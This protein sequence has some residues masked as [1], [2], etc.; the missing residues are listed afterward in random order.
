MIHD[1][2][3]DDF[4]VSLIRGTTQYFDKMY[5]RTVTPNNILIFV[6][7][8]STR[9]YINSKL[10]NRDL[11]EGQLLGFAYDFGITVA[12]L[13]HVPCQCAYERHSPPPPPPASKSALATWQVHFDNES[14]GNSQ[15]NP[16]SPK[17]E[18]S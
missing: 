2:K 13:S 11:T 3:I 12:M 10:Q 5:K 7:D 9:L 15:K 18:N 17:S 16:G 6:I 4:T 8:I 14:W 1:Y